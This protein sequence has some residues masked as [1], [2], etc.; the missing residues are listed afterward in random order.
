MGWP[1]HSRSSGP[2]A[3]APLQPPVLVPAPRIPSRKSPGPVLGLWRSAPEAPPTHR[4]C[5][6]RGSGGS[7][8]RTLLSATPPPTLFL[9]EGLRS[10]G[11]LLQDGLEVCLF[12]PPVSLPHTTCPATP[13]PTVRGAEVFRI[14]RGIQGAVSAMGGEGGS[15]WKG[16]REGRSHVRGQG[17]RVFQGGRKL[18]I[19]S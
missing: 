19:L 10:Q 5:T 14:H 11:C 12:S 16:P 7:Q 17:R 4:G 18:L 13:R 15:A 8:A 2:P 3:W 9:L 6:L 1:A